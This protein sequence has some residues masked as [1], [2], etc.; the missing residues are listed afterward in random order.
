MTVITPAYGTRGPRREPAC[1]HA[2]AAQCPR[3]SQAHGLT[4]EL[5]MPFLPEGK[6]EEQSRREP[7]GGTPFRH[8]ALFQLWPG[9]DDGYP[10]K[11]GSSGRNIWQPF[12]SSATGRAAGLGVG[13]LQQEGEQNQPRGH[14]VMGAAGSGVGCRGGP[15]N[16]GQI[17][18]EAVPRPGSR[19]G[20]LGEAQS[21]PKGNLRSLTLESCPALEAGQPRG[22]TPGTPAAPAQGITSN[23]TAAR[24]EGTQG[25]G[26]RRAARHTWA[27][28]VPCSHPVPFPPEQCPPVCR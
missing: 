4:T 15:R 19:A 1:L 28:N 20:G 25:K 22:G 6:G 3:Q 26:C 14:Q 21:K 8:G 12:G 9:R 23:S 24:T 7:P 17:R 11:V 13:W 16:K 27:Q 18:G 5:K 10:G 2:G